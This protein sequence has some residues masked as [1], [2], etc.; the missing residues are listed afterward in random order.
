MK[1]FSSLKLKDYLSLLVVFILGFGWLL[2]DQ[3]FLPAVWQR[4]VALIILLLV[5]FYL[6]FSVNKPAKTF[7]YANSI[8]LVS[9]S[10]IVIL[11]IVIHVIIKHDFNSKLILIYIV[12]GAL[13]YV[14]GFIFQKTKKG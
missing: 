14:S 4:F 1:Y 3:Y 13:P 5:L 10:F 8:A 6:Q 2:I 11:S 9:F 12:S 7:T